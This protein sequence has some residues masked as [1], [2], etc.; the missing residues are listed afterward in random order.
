MW[1][2]SGQYYGT[3]RHPRWDPTGPLRG[4]AS[5]LAFPAPQP[6]N[7]EAPHA[8]DATPRDRPMTKYLISFPAS[9]MVVSDADMVAVSEASH[10]VIREAKEAVA[11]VKQIAASATATSVQ[12]GLWLSGGLRE[13]R[14]PSLI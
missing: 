8:H 9:A 12:L 14:S 7:A 1:S 13:G 10:A 5:A 2:P 4:A 6:W 11:D 3:P